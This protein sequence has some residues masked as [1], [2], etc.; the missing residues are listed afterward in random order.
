[1]K[2]HERSLQT[3]ASPED[4]WR[5]WSDTSTWP[6]W[7]PDV[8][9]ISLEGAFASGTAGSMTTRA[10]GTHSIRLAGVQPQRGFTLVTSPAPLSTFHFSCEIAP[11]ARR[12]S[13]VR[14]LGQG[15]A[16][17]RVGGSPRLGRRRMGGPRESRPG[18][19]VK[20]MLLLVRSDE[21]WERLNEEERD[22]EAI[23]R[24]WVGLA[25]QGV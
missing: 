9:A 13:A 25:Q 12:G 22:Y 14:P 5:I 18:G 4:V 11:A 19:S 16:D 23:M 7:N 24:W 20:Y 2:I 8:T 10:G 3:K 1:M 21:E 17:E 15:P 6:D